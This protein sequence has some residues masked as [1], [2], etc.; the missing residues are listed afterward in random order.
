LQETGIEFDALCDELRAHWSE[1]ASAEFRRCVEQLRG[2]AEGGSQDAAEY[3]AEILALDGPLHDAEAAYKW[4]YVVLS[5]QGYTVEFRDQNNTPPYYGGPDGDFR[6]ESMVSGL[7][8]E[9]G[10]ARVQQ[11]DNEAAQ[12]LSSRSK[13]FRE[14]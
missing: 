7:V 12:W 4:Y 3:L 11:L 1:Q 9:L 13:Y 10:F 2:L 8:A 6:N 14:P 5:Q